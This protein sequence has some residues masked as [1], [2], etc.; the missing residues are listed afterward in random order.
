MADDLRLLPLARVIC[1]SL[2]EKEPIR[3]GVFHI[4][5]LRRIPCSLCTTNQVILQE[6]TQIIPMER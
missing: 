6:A 3:E 5:Y 4:V 2:F 1:R